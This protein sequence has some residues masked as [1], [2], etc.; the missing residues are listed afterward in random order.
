VR[1]ATG[2]EM[3]TYHREKNRDATRGLVTLSGM[4]DG[5]ATSAGTARFRDHFLPLANAGHFRQPQAPG[6][7]ELW[8]SSIGLGTYLGETDAASDVSYT[9]SILQALRS[10]INVLDT[11]IN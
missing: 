5:F 7:S 11:A 1:I 4:I 8:L 2:P 6:V 9:Q 10:G 3:R